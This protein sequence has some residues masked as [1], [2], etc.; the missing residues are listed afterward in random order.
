MGFPW[1]KLVM[2]ILVGMP[3][4]EFRWNGKDPLTKYCEN[5]DGYNGKAPQLCL[6]YNKWIAKKFHKEIYPCSVEGECGD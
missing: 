3:L 6:D 2:L 1:F 5:F 4:A